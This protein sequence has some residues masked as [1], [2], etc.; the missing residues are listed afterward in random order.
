MSRNLTLEIVLIDAAKAVVAAETIADDIRWPAQWT[1]AGI[2]L[3]E[4]YESVEFEV[5]SLLEQL[6]ALDAPDVVSYSGAEEADH[7][8][9]WQQGWKLE[10]DLGAIDRGSAETLFQ[11][12]ELLRHMSSWM[13]VEL[14]NCKLGPLAIEPS[15]AISE[16]DRAA[17]KLGIALPYWA[18]K[19]WEHERAGAYEVPKDEPAEARLHESERSFLEWANLKWPCSATEAKKAYW[20]LAAIRRTDA[21]PVNPH[22]GEILDIV[23]DGY[24]RLRKRLEKEGKK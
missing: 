3:A 21:S 15:T 4:A 2:R 12:W 8:S 18:P 7:P 16:I 5:E 10:V 11:T 24:Q 14:R 19:D 17:R 9:D 13:W 6:D 20:R 23:S 22:P 1:W